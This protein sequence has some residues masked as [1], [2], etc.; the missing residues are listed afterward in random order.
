MSPYP[1]L[2]PL[3]Y[4]SGEY[5]GAVRPQQEAH[6]SSEYRMGDLLPASIPIYFGWGTIRR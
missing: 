2:G 6:P 5:E 1:L 3:K 4:R